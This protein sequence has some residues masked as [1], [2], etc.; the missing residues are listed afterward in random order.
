[1]EVLCSCDRSWRSWLDTAVSAQWPFP[2]GHTET[3]GKVLMQT[4]YT[5]HDQVKLHHLAQ[6]LQTGLSTLETHYSLI[7]CLYV[8]LLLSVGLSLRFLPI[9]II[10]NLRLVAS[11]DRA[12]SGRHYLMTFGNPHFVCGLIPTLHHPMYAAV[13][14]L[15]YCFGSSR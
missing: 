12:R 7:P 2:I 3:F 5:S 14:S 4:A 15:S 8:S 6:P 1:M 13:C 10:R 11:R 9:R